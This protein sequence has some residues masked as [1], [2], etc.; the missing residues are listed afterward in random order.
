MYS[1][2]MKTLT[3]ALTILLATSTLALAAGEMASGT[4]VEVKEEVV[5]VQGAD[6]QTYE[7]EAAEV[8]GL[9]LKTGDVVEYEI[10]EGAPLHINK[11]S[12]M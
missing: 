8:E 7:I 6:G 1:K 11:K 12:G 9:D 2:F 4:I 3:W 5:I 10:V